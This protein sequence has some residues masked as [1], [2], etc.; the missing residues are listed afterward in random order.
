MSTCIHVVQS[1]Y[2]RRGRWKHLGQGQPSTCIVAPPTLTDVSRQGAS[3]V[4]VV[5]TDSRRVLCTGSS[6]S[7]MLTPARFVRHQGRLSRAF[8]K[9][10][11]HSK[12]ATNVGVWTDV[13]IVL[14]VGPCREHEFHFPR[15][16]CTFAATTAR[17]TPQSTL[18]SQ[19][20]RCYLPLTHP[21]P[22]PGIRDAAQH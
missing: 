9:E 17:S 22:F 1:G 3:L 21:Y 7:K 12:R 8:L 15:H 18:H 5:P 4:L 14:Q 20:T 10:K 16:S 6:S 13:T 19:S 2:T 11:E